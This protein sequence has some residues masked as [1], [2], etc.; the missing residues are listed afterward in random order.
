MKD[1]VPCCD[2]TQNPAQLKKELRSDKNCGKPFYIIPYLKTQYDDHYQNKATVALGDALELSLNKIVE[3]S[4]GNEC[5][6]LLLGRH[7]FDKDLFLLPDKNWEGDGEPDPRFFVNG[8]DKELI[9]S[10]DHPTLS[11][12]YSTVHKAKGLEADYTV[13]I[14][15]KDDKFGFP[16]FFD[17]RVVKRSQFVLGLFRK[18]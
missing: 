11:I 12:R 2:F 6:V 15:L 10:V 9:L 16:T 5:T 18:R 1:I 14:N 17:K 13:I 7:G 8:E 4:G 3:L